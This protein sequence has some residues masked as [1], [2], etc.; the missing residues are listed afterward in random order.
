[1][2]GGVLDWEAMGWLT[3]ILVPIDFSGPSRAAVGQAAAL[4]RRFQSELTLLY[5]DEVPTLLARGRHFL[6]DRSRHESVSEPDL[7]SEKAELEAFG[8]AELEHVAV[9]REFR[10]GDPAQTIVQV[11]NEEESDLILMPTHGFGP[12]RRS[13][14]GSVTAKVLHDA[15]RPVWTSAH[16]EDAKQ[17]AITEFRQLLCAVDFGPRATD[18]LSWAL[19]F[20]T[21]FGCALTVVHSI[22]VPAPGDVYFASW[23]EEA[24][25]R[26]QRKIENMVQTF[27][28]KPGIEIVEGGAP[29]ALSDA[30]DKYGAEL[31]VVGRD[32]ESSLL[33]RLSGQTYEIICRAPCAVVS[34]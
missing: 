6:R 23:Y 24:R 28:V 11:A 9:R 12:L 19:R 18:A 26:A 7:A 14:L 21:E 5:V 17:E 3:K 25:Q 8:E 20:S 27:P 1:M 2:A 13:L 10:E 29:E 32:R 34:V 31:L 22:A 16:P 4:A 15:N 30:A 33:G